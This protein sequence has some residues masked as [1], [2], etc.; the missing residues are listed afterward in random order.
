VPAKEPKRQKRAPASRSKSADTQTAAAGGVGYDKLERKDTR[1]HE[2]QI[3]DLAAVAR[4]INK[5]RGGAG[6]RITENTLIRLG[7]DL[8]LQRSDDLVGTTE[9][10]LA[11]ALQIDHKT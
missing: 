11:H 3:T 7:I 8:L 1:L 6:H 10:E 2:R 4:R 9:A 5:Q